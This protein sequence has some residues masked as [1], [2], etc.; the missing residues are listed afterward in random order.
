MP[1]PAHANPDEIRVPSV[2]EPIRTDREA[3]G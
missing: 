2:F 1:E 3:P